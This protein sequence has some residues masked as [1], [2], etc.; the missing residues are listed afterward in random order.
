MADDNAVLVASQWWQSQCS[1][2]VC[3][4]GIIAQIDGHGI[5]RPKKKNCTLRELLIHFGNRYS[6]F[7]CMVKLKKIKLN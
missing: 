3:I 1:A 6:I 7:S 4:T 5:P 2:R